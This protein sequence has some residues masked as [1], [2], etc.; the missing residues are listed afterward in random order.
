[1]LLKQDYLTKTLWRELEYY[2]L[3][4]RALPILID[5]YIYYRRNDNP[6]E[7]L[8]LFRFPVD[9]LKQ[10]HQDNF[11]LTSAGA[12]NELLGDVPKYPKDPDVDPDLSNKERL[13]TN[14]RNEQFPEETVFSINDLANLY[15][16]FAAEDERIKNFV[17][18]VVEFV[19]T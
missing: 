16:G 14:K 12:I 7:V 8:T 5:N 3:V 2:K 4:P 11:D 19:K 9:Q 1:M 18:K 15:E 13:E 6:A 17:E 10:W